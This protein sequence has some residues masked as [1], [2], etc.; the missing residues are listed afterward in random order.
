MNVNITIPAIEKLLDYT[1][2]GI[3]SVAAFL[4]SD[5]RAKKDAQSKLIA[6]EGEARVQR[7]LAD[8]QTNTL[9]M[10][11][12][13]QAEAKSILV[14]PDAVLSGEVDFGGLVQQRIRFQEEKRLFNIHSVVS[15]AADELSDKEIGDYEVD[16]D[17]A[18]RFFG[19]V[20]DVSSEDLQL[21]WAKVLAG[22][23]EHPGSTSIKTLDVLKNLDKTAAAIF[24]SLCSIC[25]LVSED[26]KVLV[27]AR[28]AALGRNSEGNALREYGLGFSQLNVLNE[29]GLIISD[30]DS[31]RDM[32]AA[33]GIRLQGSEAIHF[34]FS[35]QSRFWILRSTN[36]TAPKLEL[37]IHGV[38]LTKTGRELSKVVELTANEEY[39]N[40]LRKYF[41][42]LNLNMIDVRTWEPQ[43]IRYESS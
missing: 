19:E 5:M 21:I 36:R 23:V 37:K 38:S 8:G 12:N 14:S 20:Q 34:P 24:S 29:H 27:D 28:A 4:F 1:A 11:A 7:I 40:D 41:N 15:Q 2:S 43:Q 10:I 39:A 3:G 18:A 35:F 25:I 22:E 26:G 42:S 33:S 9:R 17:W 31:W 13:A 16:H 32:K 6:A 30:F